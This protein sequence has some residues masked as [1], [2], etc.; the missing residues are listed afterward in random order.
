[1]KDKLREFLKTGTRK[2]VM[3]GESG[4]SWNGEGWGHAW[5]EEVVEF[6]AKKLDAALIDAEGDGGADWEAWN[7]VSLHRDALTEIAEFVHDK[8]TGPAV[9]DALWDVRAMAYRALETLPATLEQQA[10]WPSDAD[11][12]RAAETHMRIRGLGM[13]EPWK[14][15]T[16]ETRIEYRRAMRAAL[17]SVRPPARVVLDEE[18]SCMTCGRIGEPGVWLANNPSVYVCKTCQLR[19]AS[20]DD[21]RV[22]LLEKWCAEGCVDMGIELEGGVYFSLAIIGEPDIQLREKN[23]IRESIDAMASELAAPPTPEKD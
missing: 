2:T 21:A 18:S 1:M 17:Q 10:E 20:R 4:H 13:L 11:V 3:R 12:E 9:P 23:T 6:N 22:D 5:N 15:M 14:T 7:A 8:S 16:E 19:L